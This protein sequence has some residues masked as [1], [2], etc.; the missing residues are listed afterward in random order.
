V[1]KAILYLGGRRD[2]YETDSSAE[3]T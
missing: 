1:I 3:A 2:R